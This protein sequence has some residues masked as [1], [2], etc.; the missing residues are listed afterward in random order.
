MT[1]LDSLFGTVKRYWYRYVVITLL[2]SLIAGI[3]LEWREEQASAVARVEANYQ[4]VSSKQIKWLNASSAV[5]SEAAVPG[6]RYPTR[7]DLT[8]LSEEISSTLDAM[9]SFYTPT[10]AISRSA[11]DYRNALSDVA[12]SINQYLPN[13]G[14]MAR[15]LTALEQASI[16][17]E[18]FRVEVD[19]YRTDAWR[20][21]L[22]VIF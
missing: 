7:D 13:E 12:G 17:G 1:R 14:A 22:S 4:L 20:S 5:F 15:L 21:F 19:Q 11:G 2:L 3:W 16:Y 18:T 8:E 6:A 9:T 10:A